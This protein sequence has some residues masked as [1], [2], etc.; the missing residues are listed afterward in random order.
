MITLKETIEVHRS[1]E[2]CF[3]YVADFR[4]TIEWDA[5]AIEARKVTEGPIGAGSRFARSCK[6][7]PSTLALS[8]TIEEFTPWQCLVLT[9]EGRWFTVKDVIT[10][11]PGG[12]DSTIITYTANFEYRY[13][14]EALAKRH[15]A[16]LRKM[17][18][19]SLRGLANNGKTKS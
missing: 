7:G 17:G 9:G 16:G 3:N 19:A 11:E 1:V 6:A 13:G 18:R 5:T 10:F 4:K 15:E 12:R 8:Y 2:A 14:L